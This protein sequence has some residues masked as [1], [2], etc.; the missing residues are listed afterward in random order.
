MITGPC[1][2]S[3]LAHNTAKKMDHRKKI[4]MELIAT[5]GSYID[6]LRCSQQYKKAVDN[7]SLK[8]LLELMELVTPCHVAFCGACTTL[9]DL[10]VGERRN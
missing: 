4:V 1:R 3:G 10:A 5:E 2:V 8:R 6:G 7:P 9:R